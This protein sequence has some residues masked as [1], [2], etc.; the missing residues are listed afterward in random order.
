MDNLTRLASGFCLKSFSEFIVFVNFPTRAK[1]SISF[2]A[3]S[4]YTSPVAQYRVKTAVK[5]A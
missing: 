1:T 4:R 2:L 3:L 5:P